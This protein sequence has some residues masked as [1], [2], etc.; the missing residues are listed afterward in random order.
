M[1]DETPGWLIIFLSGRVA[2][3]VGVSTLYCAIVHDDRH[4]AAARTAALRG[5]R[6]HDD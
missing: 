2:L 5:G 4:D 3:L 6:V 1:A